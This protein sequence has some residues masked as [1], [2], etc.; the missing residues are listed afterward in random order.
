MNLKYLTMEKCPDCGAAVK[1]EEF[2]YT[3]V[4]GGREEYKEFDCGKMLHFIPNSLP[5]EWIKEV[6]PC[7]KTKEQQSKREKREKAKKA[8]EQF[9]EELDVDKEWKSD[10]LRM[11]PWR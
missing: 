4:N 2:G 7:P 6:R 5:E 9:V 3:H 1:R 8:I 10:A 11:V